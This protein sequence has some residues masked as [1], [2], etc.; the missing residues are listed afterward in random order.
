MFDTN[1]IALQLYTVR[2]ALTQDFSGTIHKIASYGYNA[3][4]AASFPA[5]VT[6]EGAK[7]LFDDLD[8]TVVAAHSSLP[9]GTERDAVLNTMDI[10]GVSY[11]VC[12]WL[13]PDTYFSDLDG[14][15]TACDLLNEA[16][17]V[18][19]EVGLKLAY[20]NHWF[21]MKAVDGKLAYQ[22]MLDYLDDDV[23][24]ELDTYWAQ[25]AGANPTDV[26]ADLQGRLPLIHLKDGAAENTVDNMVAL[27]QGAMDI[28]AILEASQAEWH[29]V[30]LDRCD[31]DMLTAVNKSHNYLMERDV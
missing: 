31:T 8:L 17:A 21:E 15:K 11:L 1:T 28:P 23:L 29:I 4:E 6:T 24:F 7:S 27:G 10:L 14:I 30:E 3:V 9:L 2:D 16:N 26:M 18:V 20:H 5:G 13:D 22:H 19:K 12:P 25:V